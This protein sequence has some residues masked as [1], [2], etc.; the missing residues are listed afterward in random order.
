MNWTM[1]LVPLGVFIATW[2]L[3]GRV[4][5][6]LARRAI[7]D[8][9][10]ERSAHSVP[11]PRGGGLAVVPVIVV[12]WLALALAGVT[13]AGSAAIAGLAAA[14][15]LLSWF[16]DLRGL[17]IGLR[18]AAHLVAAA[19]GL[20]FLPGAGA[21]FQGVLPPALDYAA[22]ALLWVWFVNL[23]NFMDGIDGI[24]GVETAALGIGAALVA[25]SAGMAGGSAVL[26][27]SLA[28]AALAF[29]CWNWHPA[30]IFLGDV[31]S[32][33]LGYLLGWLLLSLA[34]QGLWAPAL[35]LP[36]YYLADATLTL[37][38]R[39]LRRERFWQAHRQHFYQRALGA[40]GDHGAV[41]GLVLA[42]DVL[43]MLL[44]L[45]ALTRPW[46]AVALAGIVVVALLAALQRRSRR[47]AA[48]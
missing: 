38:W 40:D 47:A 25:P 35:I 2:W 44:A 10:V 32:V 29:L 3:T 30:Q 20:A 43:L 27:L 12:A 11:V 42:G 16:D 39:L 28:A 17:P 48:G 45:L 13:P 4:R 22:A 41:A 24:T 33:A 14:L 36:L 6:W 26:A 37:A 7:L 19:A 15:A 8:R 18:L 1:M 21:V 23:F 34:G 46:P 31:G 9:P 5:A